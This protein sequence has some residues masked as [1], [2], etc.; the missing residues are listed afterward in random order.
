[1]KASDKSVPYSLVDP[2]LS[3][4]AE[5]DSICWK[6]RTLSGDTSDTNLVSEIRN[7]NNCI[8]FISEMSIVQT[9]SSGQSIAN[10]V[11]LAGRRFQLK[12][13]DA[14]TANGECLKFYCTM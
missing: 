6:P 5:I 2:I 7:I 12:K 11:I 14:T 3:R 10:T 9:N 8:A 1:M 4:G 13:M